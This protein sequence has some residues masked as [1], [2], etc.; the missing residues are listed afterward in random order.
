MSQYYHFLNKP[1]ILAKKQFIT[2]YITILDNDYKLNKI[3]LFNLINSKKDNINPNIF[4]RFHYNNDNIIKQELE[5]HKD[6][7]LIYNKQREIND[8]INIGNI[9]LKNDLK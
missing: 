1:I 9:I 5:K 3:I 7:A 6:I 4:K 8:L 2:N